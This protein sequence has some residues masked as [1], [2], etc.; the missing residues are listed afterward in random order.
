LILLDLSHTSHSLARTG[1]QRVGR[2]L[3]REL[4]AL[5]VARNITWDPYR[6]CWRPLLDWEQDGLEST[7]ASSKRG[8]QW[9]LKAKWSGRL[10]RWRQLAPPPLTPALGLIVPELFS[11]SIASALPEL[12]RQVTGPRIALFHDAIALKFPELTPSG[13]VAR[14]PAYLRELARFDGIAAISEDSRQCLLD[15]WSWLGLRNTPPVSTIPLGV[16]LPPAVV[17]ST[18]PQQATPPMLLCVGSIEGRKNHSA[19]LRAAETLWSEGLS[20]SLHLIGLANRQTGSEALSL[21]QTLQEQGRALVYKGPVDDE[22]LATAF[23]DC[24]FTIY[25]SLIEGFGLPVLESIARGRPCIC[26]GKGA[27]GESTLGGGC[28]A[29]P[30]VEEREIAQAIRLLLTNQTELA[31]LTKEASQRHI[32]TWSDYTRALLGW[33]GEL[34]NSGQA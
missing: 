21:I 16:D 2:S 26:S 20:F 22:T 33:M 31:R 8:A 9:P 34:A 14:F 29:L 10:A 27:L 4:A 15:Y 6:R 1:I 17:P 11:P 23:R 32:R 19:L 24:L 18:P 25:P 5:R 30:S 7:G 3:A 12:F 28:F 13:T